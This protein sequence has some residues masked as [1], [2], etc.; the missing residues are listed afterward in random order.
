MQVAQLEAFILNRSF[1]NFMY[2]LHN[3][4][5]YRNE[6][7]KPNTFSILVAFHKHNCSNILNH[8]AIKIACLSSLEQI[9][10]NITSPVSNAIKF[11]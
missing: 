7:L 5:N 3:F 9:Y 4:T 2:N 10:C 8:Q 6:E 11:I 1:T